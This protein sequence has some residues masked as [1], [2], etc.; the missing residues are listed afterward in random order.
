MPQAIIF[1]KPRY[2]VAECLI[3]LGE[4]RK[5]FYAKVKSGR[6]TLTKD[7][8]RSYL[9]HAALLDAA[10]GDGPGRK[11]TAQPPQRRSQESARHS[12][13]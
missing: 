2:S 13:A 1:P 4:S 10:E 12:A 6:Y 9:T 5:T 3:L 7:G 11:A 8:S